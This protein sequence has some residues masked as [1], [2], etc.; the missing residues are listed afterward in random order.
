MEIGTNRAREVPE[1]G[2]WMPERRGRVNLV[3][4]DDRDLN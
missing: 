1:A 2:S 4:D 3:T